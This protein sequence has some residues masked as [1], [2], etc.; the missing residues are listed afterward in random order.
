MIWGRAL[1]QPGAD[2][3]QGAANLIRGLGIWGP[4]LIALGYLLIAVFILPSSLY[5]LF[6]GYALGFA[7]G[8]A[9]VSVGATAGACLAF[10]I[11][12]YLARDRLSRKLSNH[13]RAIALDKA[14]GAN[15]FA[16]VFLTRLSPILPF[17]V[18]NYAYGLTRVR[19]VVFLV[20]TW[21][22]MAP[23][24]ALYIA[25]GATAKS[26]EDLGADKRALGPWGVAAL[27]IGLIAT[28]AVTVLLA[29][30]ARRA[31]ALRL[32]DTGGNEIAP[33]KES[34]RYV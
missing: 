18:L 12:R 7:I 3:L 27:A 30:L 4:V 33:D 8:W 29:R 1:F 10:L 23:G 9:T 32:D 6:A 2:A 11:S 34:S 21:L 28:L 5:S 22:G 26:V 17:G 31:L 19:F 20:A 16:I 25:I 14:V 13:P 15:G 24:G